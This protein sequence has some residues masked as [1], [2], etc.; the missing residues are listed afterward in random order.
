MGLNGAGYAPARIAQRVMLRARVDTGRIESFPAPTQPPR[1]PELPPPMGLPERTAGIHANHETLVK[2]RAEADG[3]STRLARQGDAFVPDLAG[4]SW[5]R[6]DWFTS[7]AAPL[8]SLRML[9]AG[10]RSY[11]VYRGPITVGN[12]TE[13]IVHAQRIEGLAKPLSASWTRRLGKQWLLTNDR[14]DDAFFILGG[15]MCFTLTTLPELPGLI[16]ARTS[17][18]PKEQVLDPSGSDDLAKM[19]LVIPGDNSRDLNDLEILAKDGE[20]W[21][22]WGSLLHRPLETVPSLARGISTSVL[23][24]ADGYAQ[25]RRIEAATTPATVSIQS[26]R[27]WRLYDKD[28]ALLGSGN[29]SGVIAMPAAAGPGYLLSWGEAGSSVSVTLSY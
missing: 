28:F 8:V 5:R 1:V 16:V 14:P 2:L 27:A 9:D 24:R 22:R 20:E 11:L 4:W 12:G 29:A 7:D 19:M 18:N 3:S 15:P 21:L 26:A 6:D 10:G 17:L 25:W 23:I 13:Q